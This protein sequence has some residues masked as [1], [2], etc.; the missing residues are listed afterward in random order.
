[1][2]GIELLQNEQLAGAHEMRWLY[3]I[4]SGLWGRCA[5]GVAPQ[6]EIERFAVL[7]LSQASQRRQSM[8]A[9]GDVDVVAQQLIGKHDCYVSQASFVGPSRQKSMFARVRACWVD[10]DLHKAGLAL[11][12]ELVKEIQ[13]YSRSVFFEPTLV[14]SSGRGAYLKWI[15]ERPTTDLPAWDAVQ[16]MLVILFDRF[17][18][19][20]MA[21]D[22]CR[23][24]RMLGT[25]NS[26]TAN[27]ALVRAIDGSGEEYSFERI[28]AALEELRSQM[29]M[30][31]AADAAT[32]ATTGRKRSA[33]LR[34]M[35][36]RLR[37]AAECGSV[38]ELDLYS[39]LRAPIMTSG[40]MTPASLGWA[41]F[42]DLRDLFIARG[43]IPVGMRDVSMFWMVNTLAHAGVITSNN[44]REEVQSLLRAFP[45]VG[46]GFDPVHD[47]SLETLLRRLQNTERLREQLASGELQLSDK[48]DASTLLYRPSNTHLI[49]TFDISAEEQTRLRTI[50]SA[51][52]KQRRR[53]AKAPGRAQR[54]E[55]RAALRE[56]VLAWL[57][58]HNWVCSNISA[59]AR[60]LGCAVGRVWRAVKALMQAH[61]DEIRTASGAGQAQARQVGVDN[62]ARGGFAPTSETTPV[63]EIAQTCA[64]A[65]ALS[66]RHR[67]REQESPRAKLRIPRKGCLGDGRVVIERGVVERLPLELRLMQWFYKKRARFP[68]VQEYA[69]IKAKILDKRCARA[70]SSAPPSSGGALERLRD[71]VRAQS[72][73]EQAQQMQKR[74]RDIEY[75][76]QHL[77]QQRQATQDSDRQRMIHSITQRC[78]RILRLGEQRDRPRRAD[79]LEPACRT[80]D[81]AWSG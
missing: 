47:G 9:I 26:K 64:G 81:H 3:G 78:A 69:R 66:S 20:K 2:S 16:S 49:E 52:E 68:N 76:A 42:C 57:R 18:A 53:D 1:M 35:G 77:A 36:E 75:M 6:R 34:R 44:W 31:L 39:K 70:A 61:A 58:E 79:G 60:E 71:M 63:V 72:Q 14:E 73:R 23:V 54:R 25:R 59:L 38:Q 41:R 27:G 65:F 45:Q 29:E 46:H 37:H 13:A 62:N 80:L 50:I 4:N 21:R 22:A 32:T 67:E 5:T 56:R 19:D 48:V 33:A 55:Q 51:E 43:G 17:V 24:F 74:M 15:L 40:S 7:T 8:H 12:S 28:A 11:N 10:L 30:P